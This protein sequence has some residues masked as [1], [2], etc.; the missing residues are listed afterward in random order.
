MCEALELDLVYIIEVTNM[1]EDIIR[2]NQ[3]F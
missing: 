2:Y 3:I 1:V